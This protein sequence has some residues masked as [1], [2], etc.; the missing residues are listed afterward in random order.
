[1]LK[2]SQILPNLLKKQQPIN[3]IYTQTRE[4]HTDLDKYT[5]KQL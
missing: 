4:K 1:M 2:K 5:I 3:H